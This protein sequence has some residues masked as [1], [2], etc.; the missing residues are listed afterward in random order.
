M[1]YCA[2]A[3]ANSCACYLENAECP[4][5]E[6]YDQYNAYTIVAEAQ[7]PLTEPPTVPPTTTTEIPDVNSA[8]NND[9]D[10]ETNDGTVDCSSHFIENTSVGRGRGNGIPRPNGRVNNIQSAEDCRAECAKV[11]GCNW[12]IWNSPTSRKV[13]QRLSCWLKRNDNNR[14]SNA[15]D[16]GRISGP[17]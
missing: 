4:D 11:E 5:D 13:R 8:D 16:V 12:F 3:G 9:G 14:R 10:I 1:G 2:E 7:T 6:R 17:V 15:R